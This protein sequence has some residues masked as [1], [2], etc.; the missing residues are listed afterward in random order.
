MIELLGYIGMGLLLY[1]FAI[2]NRAKMHLT[3]S[4]ASLLLLIYSIIINSYPFI[5][6]NL[7]CYV[8]NRK[9][10]LE[11]IKKEK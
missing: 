5:I 1:G 10:Y 9:R 6:L 2:K 8:I 3:L 7:A 11:E 4:Y